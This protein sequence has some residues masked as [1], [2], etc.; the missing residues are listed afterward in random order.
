MKFTVDVWKGGVKIDR[1]IGSDLYGILEVAIA[2]WGY[3]GDIEYRLRAELPK[4]SRS[5][6]DAA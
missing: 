2:M 6:Q 4:D 5:V 3:S 1:Q